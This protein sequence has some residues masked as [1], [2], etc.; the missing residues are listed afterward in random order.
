MSGG[1]DT[2]AGPSEAWVLPDHA[3]VPGETPRHPEGAFDALR[4]TARPGMPVAGLIASPAWR[5]GLRFDAAGFHWEAHEVMEPVWLALPP[6]SAERRIVQAAIQLANAR[7]KLRM[8]RPAAALRLAD[9]V[10]GLVGVGDRDLAEGM[11]LGVDWPTGALADLRAK[12]NRGG[13]SG[14]AR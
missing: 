10:A 7:L 2:D 4:D 12:A 11:G 6:N 5:A 8:G 13:R 3:Y 14:R 1:P 9:I